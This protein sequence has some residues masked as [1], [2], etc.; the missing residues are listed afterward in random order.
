MLEFHPL[1][2]EDFKEIDEVFNLC[3]IEN[4]EHCFAPMYVWSFIHPVEVCVYKK[5]VFMRTHEKGADTDWYLSPCG[6]L[7]F[8]EALD[9]ILEDNKKRGYNLEVY[10]LSEYQEEIIKAKYLDDFEIE[11]NRD[12]ADYIYLTE[13]LTNLLGKKY[14]KKRNHISRFKRDNPDYEFVLIN[15]DNAKE[16]ADFEDEWYDRYRSEYSEDLNKERLAID[17][18]LENFEELNLMGAMI[19]ID[20]KVVAMTVASA[21]SCDMVDIIIEKAIH[22]INGAYAIINN[23]FAKN[24]LQKF[25]YINR[26]DDLGEEGL[27]KAKL[28]YFP[29][30]I[31]EKINIRNK[32]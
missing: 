22:E 25:K 32:K 11:Y 23:E 9:L 1:E 30:E 14:Q 19:K 16:A 18:L 13:D 28:S 8:E 6:E 7:E 29:V 3:S 31:R 24:C 2:L 21:I 10:S 15:K 20:G 17:N 27:R 4:A 26:E 5:T 12:N